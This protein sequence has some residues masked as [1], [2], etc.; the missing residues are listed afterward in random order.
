MSPLHVL[1]TVNSSLLIWS[2]NTKILIDGIH[3]PSLEFSDMAPQAVRGLAENIPPFDGIDAL[4]FTHGH[5]D[6]FDLAKT[7]HYLERHSAASELTEKGA[8]L[9]S[10]VFLPVGG[11]Q[12]D[13]S[14][15]TLSRL[16]PPPA[17]YVAPCGEPWQELVYQVGDFKVTYL[18]TEHVYMPIW[19]SENYSILLEYQGMTIFVAGDMAF[20]TEAQLEYLKS[21]HIDYGF[22]VPFF[23]L[24]RDGVKAL[25]ALDLKRTYIYHLPFVERKGM[26]FLALVEKRAATLAPRMPSL[27]LLLPGG[28]IFTLPPRAPEAGVRGVAQVTGEG[29][30]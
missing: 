24:H 17:R 9:V 19:A 8:H 14:D 3:G 21:K 4:L 11:G 28:P 30:G 23:I 26:E 6:H 18:H 20:P 15:E 16:L 13:E 25:K 22:L 2:D 5:P 7:V 29:C 12:P 1:S 10:D 27:R